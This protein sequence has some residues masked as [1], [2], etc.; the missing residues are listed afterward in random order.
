MMDIV[1]WT[2]GVCGDGAAFLRD[3]EMVLIEEVV[4]RLNQ[5]ERDA[6]E[7][8]RLRS[9]LAAERE[10]CAKVAEDLGVGVGTDQTVPVVSYALEAMI[11]VSESIAAAIRGRK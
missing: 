8:K 4:E 10:E 7:I 1:E 11:R 9:A 2:E 3:G 5:A 6:S